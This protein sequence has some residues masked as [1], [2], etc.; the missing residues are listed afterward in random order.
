[1]KSGAG[2]LTVGT[3]TGS[4]GTLASLTQ[5]T[6][7]IDTLGAF[8]TTA[9]FALVNNKPLLVAGPVQDTGGA[10]TLALTTKTGDIALAGNVSATNI[11]DLISAGAISQTGGALVARTLTGSTA[12]SASLTQ[13]TNL[14]DTL[15]AFSTTAGF[16][17]VNNKPLLVAGPVQDTGGASTLALTTKTGD[18]T[19]AGNVSATNVVDLISAGAI[20]QTG[21]SLVARTLTGSTATSASL[22]QP[23]N[24]I[25]T[26]GAFSTTAG[27]A[28]VNNKPLLVAGPVQ[29]TGGAS[30]L[31][32]TTK[33]G[34]I[35]L[36]GDV[37]ATNV[38]DL[39]S[40]GAI[41][42]TGGS[43]VAR[44]LTGSAATSASL[45]QPTNLIDTLGAFST[46]A[47]F[48]LVN[49]EPL[50]VAG[51]VQD[52]GGASTLALT[53]KTGDITLAGNVSATNGVDLISAGAI[54]QTGGS[55]VARTLTGSAAT[56]AS[57]TQPTNLI[58]TLGAFS[59]RRASRW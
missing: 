36:A 21:G 37:S 15:G 18:I 43:L 30:T 40:A 4:A 51:P 23:T 56:L 26:L 25:D 9:G 10:S 8:S 2:A 24:L 32:L 55:L 28:L 20:S 33:T 31:A 48:A 38:V 5:P 12:T 35:A 42:Q 3:L 19:L 50:L 1:M 49:N 39:I 45:T 7:L 22:T 14:I 17:L 6:N 54:S 44:T 57:L 41:S 34:D 47:G 46:T 53:T 27:F 16:A 11:V 59:T 52:T 13:P 58:G 29:D